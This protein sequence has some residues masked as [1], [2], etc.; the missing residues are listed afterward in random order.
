MKTS[1]EYPYVKLKE[2]NNFRMVDN[3]QQNNNFG[4]VDF[5]ERIM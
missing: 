3:E 2:K 5:N 4:V 1:L